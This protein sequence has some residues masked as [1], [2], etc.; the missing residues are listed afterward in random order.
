MTSSIAIRSGRLSAEIAPLGAELQRLT[1]GEGNELLWDGNPRWWAGRAPI[2]F[3]I[4]GGLRDDRY[5][6]GDSYY[7]LPKHGFARRSLFTL[8]EQAEDSATFRLT[9][10]EATRAVYP[11]AFSLDIRFA[12][13][14][15]TLDMQA[16]VT[17]DNST[18]MPASFGYHP[19]LR[20]PLPYGGA[21]AE[22]RIRFDQP[23]PAPVRRVDGS[24]LVRPDALPTPVRARDLVLD[25]SLFVDDAVIF[26]RLTSRRLHYGVEGQRQLDI[27]FPDM[28]HLG[29][30][31]KPGADYVCV[32][33]WQ[34]HADPQ[35]YDGDLRDKPGMVEIA[36]GST[37]DFTM[38]IAVGE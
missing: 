34:G 32:E 22:H 10:S 4:V 27:R 13:R 19:A 28:P 7:T 26:D 17:N 18:P 31:M 16:S 30:W 2:L 21:R 35:G 8:V 36:P 29:I 11:F 6:L 23:E 1:D 37:R 20:W 9:D 38:R 24:G 3:P 5:R 12:I 14:D 25:D 33:P 15:A